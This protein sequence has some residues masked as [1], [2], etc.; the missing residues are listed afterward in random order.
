MLSIG[1]VLFIPIVL[2]ETVIKI[3]WAVIYCIF[4]P[5]LKNLDSAYSMENYAFKW[6][7]HLRICN[8]LY[9]KWA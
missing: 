5:L 8:W 1:L 9:N 2:L 4:R 7:G 3:V 6:K